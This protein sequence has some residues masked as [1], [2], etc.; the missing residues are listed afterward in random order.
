MNN[1]AQAVDGG[2][3]LRLCWIAVIVWLPV[4]LW[5][6]AV[7]YGSTTA[8]V[9]GAVQG[10]LMVLVAVMHGS[11][12]YGWRGLLAFVVI[13]AALTFVLEATSIAAGFPF[14]YYVHHGAPGPAPLGVPISVLA[15]Y[16]VLGWYSWALAK[17]ITCQGRTRSNR[18]GPLLTPL[19]GAFILAGFDYP[20]DPIGSTVRE[21]WSFRDPGGQYG[22]PLTNYLGWLFSGWVVFQVF[23]LCESRFAAAK[24]TTSVRYWALPVVVWLGLALQYP[25]MYAVAEDRMVELAGSLYSVADIYEASLAASLFSLVFVVVLAVDRLLAMGQQGRS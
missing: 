11:L 24:A 1:Q 14:G 6:V 4:L 18:L 10:L 22:V 16:V 3:R 15:G 19:V 13:A 8:A 5:S 20:Y 9:T 17:L 21:M 2:L 7:E 12:C 23:S 25:I